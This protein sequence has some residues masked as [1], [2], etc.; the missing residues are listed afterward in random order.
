MGVVLIEACGL[1]IYCG[2]GEGLCE[3][4]AR[5]ERHR[6]AAGFQNLVNVLQRL[7]R[8]AFAAHYGEAEK[9]QV[10]T[11]STLDKTVGLPNQVH[12]VWA[13]SQRNLRLE[14]MDILHEL[15]GRQP[16][17]QINGHAGVKGSQHQYKEAGAHKG[18]QGTVGFGS[19]LEGVSFQVERQCIP[20]HGNHGA[21]CHANLVGVAHAGGAGRAED[22]GRFIGHPL[23]L[24]RAVI[25][26]E[27]PDGR[28][29]CHVFGP[30]T[31]ADVQKAGEGQGLQDDYMLELLPLESLPEH[32]L[33]SVEYEGHAALA[34]HAVQRFRCYHQVGEVGGDARHISCQHDVDE[35]RQGRAEEEQ[36]VSLLQAHAFDDAAPQVHLLHK[37]PATDPAPKIHKGVVPVVIGQNTALQELPKRLQ[38]EFPV[39]DF[40]VS[41]GVELLPAHFFRRTK[42]IA[43][44]FYLTDLNSRNMSLGCCTKDMYTCI[45]KAVTKCAFRPPVGMKRGKG[46]DIM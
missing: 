23:R 13:G 10:R 35:F 32:F 38:R 46:T 34:H 6:A 41:A 22:V 33:H 43:H 39:Q 12:P 31:Q 8:A 29:G 26:P 19:F 17:I 18:R 27:T 45:K 3:S 5:G 37:L 25:G 14:S 42:G 11:L 7:R 16:G 28:C 36:F 30:E 20:E 21:V 24:Q 2:Y 44:R 15:P 9:A 40:L 1:I 4:V